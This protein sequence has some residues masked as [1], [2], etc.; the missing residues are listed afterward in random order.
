MNITEISRGILACL[1]NNET[2]NAGCIVTGQGIVVV[3][4]LDKPARARQLAAAMEG[5]FSQP[6]LYVVNTHHHYDHVLGN[7]VFQ[8]PVIANSAL[9]DQLAA[10]MARDL[11]PVAIAAWISEHPE[12]RWLA[13]E[14]EP[15]Y[16]TLL[17]EQQMEIELAPTRLVLLHLGGHTPDSIVVDLPEA[18]VL[19]AGDLLFEGRMPFMRYAHIAEWIQ[20]LYHLESLGARTIVPGH[21]ALCDMA[22]LVRFR[23][24]LEAL[25]AG[26]Q[27]LVARGWEKGDVMDSDQLPA[28]WTDD[29]P[30]LWRAN[31]GRVYDELVGNSNSL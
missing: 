3:D 24:Y 15:V 26:V 20:A 14:L 11:S 28:W 16:P 10:A 31:V 7:Q 19:Y 29:R 9:P 23:D 13:D 30:E 22:Y 27:S 6:V 2:A 21:G 12:D 8:A 18:G 4:S 1:T 17:F 25:Q 5:M